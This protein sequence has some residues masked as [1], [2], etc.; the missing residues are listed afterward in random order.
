MW[1]F[2][3]SKTARRESV[4]RF[5]LDAATLAFGPYLARGRLVRAM[6]SDAYV[7]GYVLARLRGLTAYA[8]ADAR[9]PAEAGALSELVLSTFFGPDAPDAVGRADHIATGAERE[10]YLAGANDGQAQCDYLFGTREVREHPHYCAA[11]QRERSAAAAMPGNAF[12]GSAAAIAHHLEH[13]TFA[14]YFE[15]EHPLAA[16]AHACP[17][18]A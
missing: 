13:F 7:L 6:Q 16:A 14:A 5:A 8:S 10:R 3:N 9:L 11:L 1:P 18:A 2:R 15:R 4:V 12:N 17:S